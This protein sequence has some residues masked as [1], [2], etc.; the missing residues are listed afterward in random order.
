[1]SKP[2][3]PTDVVVM[4]ADGNNAW[5]FTIASNRFYRQRLGGKMASATVIPTDMIPIDQVYP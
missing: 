4:T 1:M 2:Q 3:S 5:F